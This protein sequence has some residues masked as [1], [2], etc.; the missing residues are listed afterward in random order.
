MP[1]LY[2]AGKGNLGTSLY[3]QCIKNGV[4]VDG[5]LLRNPE[6][7]NP[8]EFH[9]NCPLESDSWVFLAIPDSA[10]ASFMHEHAISGVRY[11]HC[12][13]ATSINALENASQYGV[14]YPLQTFTHQ[15][16][17]DWSKIQIFIE[18]PFQEVVNDLKKFALT[19]QSN[20]QIATSEERLKLHLAAVFTNNFTNAIQWFVAEFLQKN[21]LPPEW[22]Y[23]LLEE[24]VSK[25]IEL[26]P[27]HSQTGPA[28]RNDQ[29]TID[30]HLP[31]LKEYPEW[32][33]VYLSITK[34]LKNQ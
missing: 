9:L 13:G 15:R 22:M 12:S 27:S 11:I 6:P 5:F 28:I 26:G 16:T 20:A 34:W 17:I 29:V 25:L 21:Q 30:K 10:I 32:E 18:S 8:N 31:L 7:N 19:I 1:K 2:I 23:P 33:S 24:T 4:G 3:N 14:F